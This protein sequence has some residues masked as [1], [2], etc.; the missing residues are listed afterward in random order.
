LA[1]L[2]REEFVLEKINLSDLR[3]KLYVAGEAK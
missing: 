2:S 3:E 1:K